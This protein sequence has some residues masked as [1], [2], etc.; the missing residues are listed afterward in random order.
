MWNSAMGF[1]KTQYGIRSAKNTA[2]P[3]PNFDIYLR[4]ASES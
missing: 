4:S 1:S 3:S 2:Q